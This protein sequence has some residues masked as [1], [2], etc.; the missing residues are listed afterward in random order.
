MPYRT[1]DGPD[2]TECRYID[3]NPYLPQNFNFTNPTPIKPFIIV[4]D[5]EL[6]NTIH[7]RW[8]GKVHTHNI[9]NNT[10]K[11]SCTMY[12]EDGDFTESLN[13]IKARTFQLITQSNDVYIYDNFQIT[14]VEGKYK[15]HSERDRMSLP[16]LPTRVEGIYVKLEKQLTENN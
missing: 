11:K 16:N 4:R 7:C 8:D 1:I 6:N 14:E 2:V 9:E 5:V 12:F 13:N 15:L 3:N 10:K